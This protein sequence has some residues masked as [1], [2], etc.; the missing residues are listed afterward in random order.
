LIESITTRNVEHLQGTTCLLVN[1]ALY[2]CRLV[3]TDGQLV[4]FEVHLRMMQIRAS[5]L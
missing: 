3:A 2:Q 4:V 5:V 1:D